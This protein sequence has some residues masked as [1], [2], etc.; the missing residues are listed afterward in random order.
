MPVPALELKGITKRFGPVVANHGVDLTVHAGEIHAVVGENG[1]G[2]S[3]LLQIAA[4]VQLADEG[5]IRVHGK[6]LVRPSAARAIARGV[7]MV[8]QHFLLIPPLTVAENVVLGAEPRRG[9]RLDRKR[10][11]ADVRA[12]SERFGLTVDPTK[13]VETLSVGEQQRVEILKVLYRNADIL[14]LDE[15]TAVLAPVEVEDLFRVLRVLVSQGRTVIFVTHKLREVMEVS[16][17]VTVLRRGRVVATARTTETSMET[18][19][20]YVVGD[21]TPAGPSEHTVEPGARVTDTTRPVL[22][23]KDLEVLGAHGQ[24]AV[25][26]VSL[27]VGPG[28]IVGI[29]GVQGNGQTE[30]IEAIAG[31]LPSRGHIE[32]DGRVIDTLSPGERLAAGL[33]HIPEDRQRRG[34]ILEFSIADNLILG[35][36]RRYARFGRLLRAKIEGN[37]QRQVR[38][39]DIRPPRTRL[40]AGALSGGN[41]QKVVVARELSRQPRAILAAQPTRGV[42][43]GAM[44]IIHGALK[45]ARDS[46]VGILLVSADLAELI[47]LSNRVL[48]MYRGELVGE[49]PRSEATETA[50]GAL[51]VGGAAA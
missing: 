6:P 4:G 16:D 38:A 43:I 22:S 44:A 24:P 25:R 28:E 31:L 42:D 11:E 14:I 3:T 27:E 23:V 21:E 46:G 35:A 2:K 26:G 8:Q 34:L 5:E 29:A 48:V 49:F 19:A 20:R 45:Q 13:R 10:A 36:Q 9:L 33:A 30:L 15:P 39:F 40:A 17:R 32:L 47:E 18:L 50:I 51:M 7:G 41:Q 1:A 12:L 37:A